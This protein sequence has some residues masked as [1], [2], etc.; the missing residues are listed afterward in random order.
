MNMRGLS[1]NPLHPVKARPKPRTKSPT[2]F[3]PKPPLSSFSLHNKGHP[4]LKRLFLSLFFFAF[5]QMSPLS[6]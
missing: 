3:T 1:D 4:Q 6:H 2:L 5:N